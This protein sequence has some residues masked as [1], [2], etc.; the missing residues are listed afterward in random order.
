MVMLSLEIKQE[1]IEKHGRGVR[2][3]DLSKQYGR[4]ISAISTIIKQ[5]ETIKAV[6]PSKGI[7]I[8]SKRCSPT[9]EEM[10]CL[11]LI[12]RK[13]KEIAGDTITEM[14]ICEKASAIYCYMKSTGSGGDAGENSTDSTTGEFKASCGWFEK[15]RNRSGIH[16]VVR[17]GE[18][19]SSDIKAADE[20]VK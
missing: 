11:L 18:A 14:I 1:I 19:S 4:N 2:V 9:L 3:S 20:F 13:D 8:I 10:E 6:K 15:F 5:K 16:S 7:T 17:H 12:W